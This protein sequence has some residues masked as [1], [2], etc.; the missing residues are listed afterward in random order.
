MITP[1]PGLYRVGL[2]GA[3]PVRE[4]GTEALVLPICSRQGHVLAR[5]VST[6][7]YVRWAGR[8]QWESVSVGLVSPAWTRDGRGVCGLGYDPAG[9]TRIVCHWFDGRR[10]EALVTVGLPLLAVTTL[11]AMFL[12][13]EDAPTIVVDRSARDLYALEWDA[14]R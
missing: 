6:G 14:P 13:P 7:A 11:P 8:P 4:P 5:G 3:R 1:S 10:P 2:T 12:D 9:A